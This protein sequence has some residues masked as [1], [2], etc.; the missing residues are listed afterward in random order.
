VSRRRY[1]L[2]VLACLAVAAAVAIGLVLALRGGGQTPTRGEYLARVSSVCKGYARRLAR[3]GVP[4]DIAA[5]GEVVSVVG[6]VL[7]LLKGQAAAMAAVEPPAELQPRLDRLFALTRRSVAEL[8]TTLAA[9]N[10]RHAGA[11]ATG[12]A[13]F[14]ATRDRSHAL[15]VAIGIRC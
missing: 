14:S 2:V 11:V 4:G 8:D 15:A 10:R 7:P 1:G 9:A 5:F 12:L 13:R 6:Q 3:I